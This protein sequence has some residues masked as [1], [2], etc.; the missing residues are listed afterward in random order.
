MI[1]VAFM[2]LRDQLG[3]T[4]CA[5]TQSSEAGKRHQQTT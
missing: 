3:I 2:R 4:R 1:T 5:A